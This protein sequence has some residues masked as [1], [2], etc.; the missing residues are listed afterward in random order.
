M[1]LFGIFRPTVANFFLIPLTYWNVHHLSIVYSSHL[2]QGVESCTKEMWLPN[3]KM[4]CVNETIYIFQ[5]FLL[6]K[7]NFNLLIMLCIT[8]DSAMG[9]NSFFLWD[10]YL[11]LRETEYFYWILN[12]RK[13]TNLSPTSPYNVSETNEAFVK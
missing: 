13:S 11:R 1:W 12:T 6:M 8:T 10:I 3:L 7:W 4:Y 5:V 9:G 2:F